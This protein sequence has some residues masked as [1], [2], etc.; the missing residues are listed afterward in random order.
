[1]HFTEKT[2]KALLEA[3][4][5]EGRKID[6]SEYEE[7]LI[8]EGYPLNDKTKDFLMEFGGLEVTH[9]AYVMPD[10]TDYFHFDPII[11]TDNV[12]RKTVSKYEER[13]GRSVD[14]IGE[15]FSSHMVLMMDYEGKIYG[16]YDSFLTCLGEN[17]YEAINNLCEGKETE[18]IE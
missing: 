1:M 15:A 9:D 16:G 2:K 10:E 8:S 14:V 17:L 3:G 4:W 7:V 13:I 18:E 12:M 6:I 11:A 5:Y